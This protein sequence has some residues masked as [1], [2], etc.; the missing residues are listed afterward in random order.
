MFGKSNGV[1][2]LSFYIVS[3][4]KMIL[5]K[6]MIRTLGGSAMSYLFS[7]STFC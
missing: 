4:L 3:K 2:I 1:L 7:T 6:L 5:C